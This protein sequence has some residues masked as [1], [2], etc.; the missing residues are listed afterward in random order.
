[1]AEVAVDCQK[2]KNAD[3]SMN[4]LNFNANLIGHCNEGEI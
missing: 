2:R 1:M 4:L 3:K